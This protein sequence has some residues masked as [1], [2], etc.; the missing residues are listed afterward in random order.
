MSNGDV[1][2]SAKIT[3]SVEDSRKAMIR[4]MSKGDIFKSVRLTD[5][6][7]FNLAA[8]QASKLHMDEKEEKEED[9]PSFT[10]TS[11]NAS[12]RELPSV[13]T[14]HIVLVIVATLIAAP[15]VMVT[16][17]VSTRAC[18]DSEPNNQGL[19]ACGEVGQGKFVK[20]WFLCWASYVGQL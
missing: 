2:K 9:A 4:A 18:W 8:R 10:R 16:A 7:I 1:F 15:S 11:S 17:H 19:E 6:E 3:K 14:L 12:F 5:D 13:S 20:P